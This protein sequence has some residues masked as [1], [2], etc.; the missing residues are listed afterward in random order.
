MDIN[1][2]QAIINSIRKHQIEVKGVMTK[3]T[4]Q[5]QERAIYHDDSK[6]EAPEFS[7]FVK[8]LSEVKNYKYGTKEYND[9]VANN[10][11]CK[12]HFFK[13]D[14]HPENFEN[15]I[16]NMNL[17]N[18]TEMFADWVA[19]SSRSGKVSKP[20]IIENIIKLSD[21]FKLDN[22]L[23]QILINTVDLIL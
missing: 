17:I 4:N 1:E 16:R 15:G 2:K 5:L 23:T 3:I 11:Y 20:E 13:N 21:K 7:M 12:H 9:F 10:E 14:H 6:L 22:I 8:F 18:I 19:S